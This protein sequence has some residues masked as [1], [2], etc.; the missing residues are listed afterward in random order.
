LTVLRG[1]HR[2]LALHGEGDP[3]EAVEERGKRSEERERMDGSGFFLFLKT[4][5]ASRLRVRKTTRPTLGRKRLTR[6]RED[7][8]E[9]DEERGERSEERERKGEPGY[10]LFLKT[11]AASRLRVRKRTGPSPEGRGSREV[12][13]TRRRKTRREGRGVRREKERVSLVISFS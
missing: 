9:E 4:L 7:A 8:K 13:K 10:F 1:L 2:R 12:A 5:A 11:L 3:R 6:S